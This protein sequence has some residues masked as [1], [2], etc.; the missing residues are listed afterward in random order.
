MDETRIVLGLDAND[1]ALYLYDDECR[2]EA[3]V[4]EDATPEP[5]ALRHSGYYRL[6]KE[7]YVVLKSRE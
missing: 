1:P 6:G 2:A 5:P 4:D 3:L 7:T